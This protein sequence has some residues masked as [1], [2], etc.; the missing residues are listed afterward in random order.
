MNVGLFYSKK[1][2]DKKYFVSKNIRIAEDEYF[3]AK[4]LNLNMLKLL[5]I[6]SIFIMTEK[7]V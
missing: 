4:V 7:I 2:L 3:L 6:Q 1:I 5:I